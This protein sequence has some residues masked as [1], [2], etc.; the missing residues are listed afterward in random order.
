MTSDAKRLVEQVA[1]EAEATRDAPMPADATP[2][3]PHKTITVATRLT[4]DDVA[5]IE[6]LADRAG[7]AGLRPRARVDSGRPRGRQER[8]GDDGIGSSQRR[9]AAP[10]RTRRVTEHA[11]MGIDD[12]RPRSP[13]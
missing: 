7:R 3:K 11:A 9:R 6:A 12:A 8:L 13:A 4:A 10:P 5:Q 2:T 1:A